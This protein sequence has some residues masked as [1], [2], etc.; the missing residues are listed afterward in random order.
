MKDII[1]MKQG[2]TVLK[3]LNRSRFEKLLIADI[4]SRLT[5][6][7]RFKVSSLQ[8]TVYAEPEDSD[9][10][11][12]G[13]FE[14]MLK[15]FGIVTAVR[16]AACEKNAEAIAEKATEYL[17]EAM[18]KASSFKVETKRSD[19]SFPMTSPELSK[20]LGARLAAAYP[21]TKA[22]MHTPELTVNA[23]VR[24][25][26]AFIHSAPSQ[27]AGG[28]PR[29]SNG[30]AVVLLSGGIDSPVAAYLMAKRGVKLIPL[31]FFSFP[32]TSEQAKRKVADIA[33]ILSS[34]CGNLTVEMTPFTRIQEEI[35]KNCPV[36]LLTIISRRFMM[37]I[38]EKT[39]RH[40]GCGALITGENLGQVASQTMESIEAVQ[41]CVSLPVYRP[42]IG[43][44]KEEIVRLA[45]KIGTYDVSV[46]PFED[47]CSVFTPKHP[48][49][50]PKINSVLEAE[51]RLDTEALT[52]EAFSMIEHEQIMTGR[53]YYDC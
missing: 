38:A 22:D 43:A 51:T 32:Y 1:L 19:K 41:Q 25:R 36:E 15:V 12:S 8:S 11:M 34:Y 42:L 33:G 47:C 39:A 48:K 13:A 49:T 17:G 18:K 35:R 46:L 44:D 7:G 9:C 28:L 31:H 29:G 21:G 4:K 10:D 5:E 3:G 30:R 20:Y 24:D 37:R 45:R 26:A 2:E 53:R 27:G 14:D 16:A 50:K 6:F 40:Y 23:E 52:E